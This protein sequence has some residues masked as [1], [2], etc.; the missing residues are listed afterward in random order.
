MRFIDGIHFE[1]EILSHLSQLTT[2]IFHIRTIMPL[3]HSHHYASVH[4][5][6]NTFSHWKYGQVNC[7]VDYISGKAGQGHIYSVPFQMEY[8]NGV[9]NSFFRQFISSC[10]EHKVIR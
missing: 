9:T 1:K 7:H 10:Y 2:F 6:Q 3:L 5:I 4:D 8:I